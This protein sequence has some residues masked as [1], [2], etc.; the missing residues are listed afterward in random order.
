MRTLPVCSNLFTPLLLLVV[1]SGCAG[2]LNPNCDWTNNPAL[3][4]E[5]RKPA[6]ERHLTNDAMIA[7]ELAIRHADTRRG[8]RSGHFAGMD[9]YVQTREQCMSKLFAVVADNHSVQPQQV[10]DLVGGR[11]AAFDVAVLLSFAILYALVSNVL[12]RGMVG[13][14]P[15]DEP[16]AALAATAITSAMVSVGGLIMFTLWAATL[17]MMRIGNT[18]MSY[19]VGRVPWGHHPTEL[20]VG[21]VVL[22]WLIVLLHHLATSHKLHRLRDEEPIRTRSM[23]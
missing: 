6:D 17:E 3:P 14:F 21:G 2:R 22:F 5:L 16:V 12:G 7:E 11:P 1:L 15:R 8:H 10:R 13:R 4:L 19:R 23:T 18:H 20:F 9:A